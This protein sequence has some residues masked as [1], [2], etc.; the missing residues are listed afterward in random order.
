MTIESRADFARRMGW[1]R[2]HVSRACQKGRLVQS[3]D[4]RIEVEAS[5]ARYEQTK[6][7][8]RQDVAARHAAA[9]SAAPAPVDDPKVI[10]PPESVP[11]SPIAPQGGVYQESRAKRERFAA[12]HAEL[13]YERAAGRLVELADVTRAHRELGVLLRQ[14]LERLPDQLAPELA[15]ETDPGRVHA[16]LQ[17]AM[18]QALRTV[19]D[20]A[21][22]LATRLQA[23]P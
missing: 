20:R 10:R 5:I 21:Q 16:M 13:D 4:G 18:E 22:A 6:D 12:M 19:S 9:R 2:A 15:P 23:T 14:A 1:D 17:T 7:P 3:A 11:E 8:A